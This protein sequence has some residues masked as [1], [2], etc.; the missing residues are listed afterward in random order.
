M[1]PWHT[2]IPGPQCSDCFPC[3]QLQEIEGSYDIPT[4]DACAFKPHGPLE[5]SSRMNSRTTWF[6]ALLS[7]S[8]LYV[9]SRMVMDPAW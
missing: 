7:S 5:F 2:G 8:P 3:L 4:L 9:V 1:D 6:S